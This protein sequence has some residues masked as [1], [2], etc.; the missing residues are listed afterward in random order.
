MLMNLDKLRS[1]NSP[2]DQG[3]LHSCHDSR[4]RHV[5]GFWDASSSV[6]M[7]LVGT[8]LVEEVRGMDLGRDLLSVVRMVLL[9]KVVGLGSLSEE[10]SHHS[11]HVEVP[12]IVLGNCRSRVVEGDHIH[13]LVGIHDEVVVSVV[14]SRDWCLDV[15]PGSVY[16]ISQNERRTVLK[17]YILSARHWSSFVVTS[18]QLFDCCFQVFFCFELDESL[19]IASPVSLRVHNINTGTIASK[20]LEILPRSFRSQTLDDHSIDRSSWP[21]SSTICRA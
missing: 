15:R 3:T 12:G 7:A 19:A 16:L 14:D 1:P 2:D 10:D 5:V 13:L 6:G 20:V 17:T 21:G 18:I 9:G 11:D 8:L 4:S